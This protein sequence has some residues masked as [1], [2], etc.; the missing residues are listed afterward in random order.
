MKTAKDYDAELRAIPRES[1][2]MEERDYQE[3]VKAGLSSL[4]DDNSR[5]RAR[6][7]YRTGIAEGMAYVILSYA[8]Y[9]EVEL[10]QRTLKNRDLADLLV[11]WALEVDPQA[12]DRIT[13]EDAREW[14]VREGY[15]KDPQA[16]KNVLVPVG[17]DYTGE[18]R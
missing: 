7:A 12:E 17:H 5:G 14:L 4:T 9:L 8:R 10:E 3:N 15:I 18:E 2:V 11:S 1:E 13:Q 6:L 16:P